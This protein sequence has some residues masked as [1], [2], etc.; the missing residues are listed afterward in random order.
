MKIGKLLRAVA[1]IAT[2]F[3]GCTPSKP[4]IE[5]DSSSLSYITPGNYA[6]IKSVDNHHALVYNVGSR[7]YIRFSY[8]Q[9]DTWSEPTIVAQNDKYTYT[10]CELLQLQNR[11]LLYMW[12]ARPHKG[13]NLRYKIMYAISNDG[14][15]EWSAERDLYIADSTFNNGCWEPIA[16]QLPDGELQIYFANEGPYTESNEQEI[17]LMRSFDNGQS[18]GKAEK[19]SFRANS[20]DG[21]AS[22]IYL[23]HSNQIAVAIEDNGIRGRFKPVIVRTSNNWADG[24]VTSNDSRRE[25]AIAEEYKLH[26]TIY[27]GAPYLIRLGDDFTLLSIQSTEFR[28]GLNERYANMQVYVG[29]K[30]ARNFSNR[31]T[32]VADLN[33][34]GNSLWNSISQINSNTVIAVMDMNSSAAEKRGIWT[35]KGRIV[36]SKE[37]LNL[38]LK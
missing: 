10:N 19:I 4:T 33:K 17:S 37:Q 6:R 5:W 1:L 32:P 3:T 13:T 23:P 28:K 35:V 18:W 29:D 11:Q 21:M 7:A 12:N 26:D 15:K 38:W 16:L 2:L 25:E 8:D 36:K 14:G 20:R 27:A 9:C 34:E 30:D 31:S 24:C 22:P